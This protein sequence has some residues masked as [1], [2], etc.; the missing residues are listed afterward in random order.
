MSVE[1]RGGRKPDFVLGGGRE[2]ALGNEGE[3]G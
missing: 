2:E 3:S 1:Q